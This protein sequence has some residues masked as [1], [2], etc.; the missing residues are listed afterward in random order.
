MWIF[1]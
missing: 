1:Q